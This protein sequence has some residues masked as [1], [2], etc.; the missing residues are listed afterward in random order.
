MVCI[1][2]VLLGARNSGKAQGWLDGLRIYVRGGRGGTG[3]PR[4]DGVGGAGGD[5]YIR[6]D[7]NVKDLAAVRRKNTEQRYLAE[8]G[9]NSV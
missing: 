8:H 6:A 3:L 7:E 5:V 1:S 2:R 4:V 9:E